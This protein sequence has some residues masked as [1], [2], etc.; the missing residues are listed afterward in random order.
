MA[1]RNGA[2]NPTLQALIAWYERAIAVAEG[3]R[4]ARQPWAFA[5]YGDGTPIEP[6]HRWIYAMRTSLQEAHPDPFDPGDGRSDER[7]SFL[8][9]VRARAAQEHPELCGTQADRL[10]AVEAENR[11]L[12]AELRRLKKSMSWRLTKPLRALG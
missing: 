11:R 12:K 5:T 10:A 1:D 2:G 4:L 3:D 8:A 7:S 6:A 9:W